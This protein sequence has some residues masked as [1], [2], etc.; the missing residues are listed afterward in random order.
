MEDV[1]K[2]K[3]HEMTPEEEAKFRGELQE[4][5]TAAENSQA[6]AALVQDA[7]KSGIIGTD[8]L[9]YYLQIF[10]VGEAAAKQRERRTL[11]KMLGRR[12]HGFRVDGNDPWMTIG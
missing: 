8:E 10:G 5:L 3:A 9:D 6:K 1:S 7:F 2:P 12:T 11:G 4:A